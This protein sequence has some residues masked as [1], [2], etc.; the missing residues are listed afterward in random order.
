MSGGGGDKGDYTN[1]ALVILMVL[2]IVMIMYWHYVFYYYLYLWRATLIPV[3]FVFQYI[4]NAILDYLFFWVDG[5]KQKTFS[6]IYKLTL[7]SNNHFFNENIESY[8]YINTFIS[9]TIG[10]FLYSFLLYT[11]YIIYKKKEFNVWILKKGN[12]TSVDLLIEKE[13][14]VWPNVKFLINEHPELEKDIHKGKWRVA[15]TPDNFLKNNDIYI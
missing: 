5:D 10:P 4:P 2:I 8:D 1:A 7:N 3:T 15:E 14:D 9:K 6:G 13:S 11:S 12:K